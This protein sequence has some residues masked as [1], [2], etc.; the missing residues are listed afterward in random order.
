MAAG[1][2]RPAPLPKRVKYLL[3]DAHQ[4]S[5][6]LLAE[7]KLTPVAIAGRAFVFIEEA[8]RVSKKSYTPDEAAD[9]IA[10]FS[11][12]LIGL[13]AAADSGG[14]DLRVRHG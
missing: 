6:D 10:A 4:L 13:T 3:R 9:V 1:V 14:L 5:V 8:A 12:A 2:V 7:Q 11:T